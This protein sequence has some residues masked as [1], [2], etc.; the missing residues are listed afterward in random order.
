MAHGLTAKHYGR[1]V[2]RGGFLL[3]LAAPGFFMDTTDVWL[4]PPRA[5]IASASAGVF[6]DAVL[7]G[8]CCFAQLLVEPGGV[9]SGLLYQVA[10][11]GYAETAINLVPL[12]ELDGYYILVDLLD[13]P[14]L[15]E[16]SFPFW[17]HEL[18]G[19]LARREPLGGEERLFVVFGLLAAIATVLAVLLALVFW[20]A[21]LS[22]VW[23]DLVGGVG[24]GPALGL[25]VLLIAVGGPLAL[26]ASGPGPREQPLTAR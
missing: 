13:M 20:Q 24:V 23:A 7:G 15:R 9:A 10:F 19:R 1:E 12:I 4:A 11:V 8:L 5:R 14:R 26:R 2:P 3:Y 16:R 22:L 17:R 21:Q 6:S 25:L 18:P